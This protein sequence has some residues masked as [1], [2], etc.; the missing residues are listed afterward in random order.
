VFVLFLHAHRTLNSSL[1]IG[2]SAL[3][4]LRFQIGYR[5][6]GPTDPGRGCA[7]P[8]GLKILGFC[9]MWWGKDLSHA[10]TPRSRKIFL[11]SSQPEA[12]QDPIFYLTQRRKGGQ[13]WANVGYVKRSLSNDSER[14][15]KSTA[16]IISGTSRAEGTAEHTGLHSI[17]ISHAK[18]PRSR[19]IF[20]LAVSRRRTR[21]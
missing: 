5:F 20:C 16:M 19:K 13:R 15:I 8:S 18:T 14:G 6:P 9:F 11:F 17:P 12:Y 1:L 2:V 3:R 21:I 10:K 4:A 7:S